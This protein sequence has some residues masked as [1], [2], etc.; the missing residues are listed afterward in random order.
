MPPSYANRITSNPP[1]L[2]SQTSEG[3]RFRPENPT[4][5]SEIQNCQTG[6]ENVLIQ[7]LLLF[8]VGKPPAL[9][10]DMFSGIFTSFMDQSLID[11]SCDDMGR[12]FVQDSHDLRD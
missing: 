10:S 3:V 4:N 11:Q 6:A 12:G 5:V 7:E 1:P 9:D 2:N 8:S